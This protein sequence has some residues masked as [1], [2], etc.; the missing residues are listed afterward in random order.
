MQCVKEPTRNN[1]LLDLVLTD[2]IGLLKTKVLPAITDHKMVSFELLLRMSKEVVVERFVWQ[3]HRADWRGLRRCLAVYDWNSCFSGSVTE[4][5]VR[6]S[7]AILS[8][9][10]QYIP[11]KAVLIS[12]RDHPWVNANCKAAIATKTAC[13]GTDAYA[14]ARDSCRDVLTAEYKAY[15][16]KLREQIAA[17]PRGSKLWWK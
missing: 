1:Y 17:L 14:T 16:L 8:S 13:E 3:Y 9:A 11:Y 7:S 5:V 6:V 10:K 2:S 12:K 4:C 15:V